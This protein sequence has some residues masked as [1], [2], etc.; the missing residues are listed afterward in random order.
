MK[1]ASAG[2]PYGETEV[3]IA[4]AQGKYL[5]C[6]IRVTTQFNEE[7]KPVRVIGVIIDIDDE[8]R[9][10]KELSAKVQMDSLTKV[11]NKDTAVEPGTDI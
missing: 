4:N 8:K 11:F 3:R 5:W 2:I 7:K 6:R 10:I 1:S 9:R